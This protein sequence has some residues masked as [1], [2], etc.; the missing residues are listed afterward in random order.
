MKLYIIDKITK[1]KIYLQLVAPDKT[2][3]SEKIGGQV[4]FFN[5]NNYSVNEVRA[6]PTTD[7]AAVGG[8]LGGFIGSVGGA[9]GV[10]LGGLLGAAIGQ[11][12]ADKEKKEAERFNGSHI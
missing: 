5:G 1:E 12:Q 4:F 10:I 9:G 6:E 2:E 3:F 8:L 7:S 11:S